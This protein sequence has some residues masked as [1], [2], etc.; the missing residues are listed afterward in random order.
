ME[1][2]NAEVHV[3][4]WQGNKSGRWLAS[5]VLVAACADT[6]GGA[7]VLVRERADAGEAGPAELDAGTADLGDAD[8][9]DALD[10]GEVSLDAELPDAEIPADAGAEEP[11]PDAATAA[12]LACLPGVY[13][14]AFSGQVGFL[15]GLFGSLISTSIR[16]NIEI[17]VSVASAGSL[18]VVDEG[19]VTGSDQDGNPISALVSGVLDCATGTLRSGKLSEGHYRSGTSDTLFT[20]DVSATYTAGPPTLTGTW[21]TSS[22]FDGGSGVF[23][24]V[25]SAGQ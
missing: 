1:T 9:G 3:G 16:G 13:R 24:A 18:L 25:L 12:V 4:N 10:G 23:S 14:G 21:T 17:R 8:A 6:G 20:G 15:P 22:G 2:S 5:A 7:L 11:S 19:S